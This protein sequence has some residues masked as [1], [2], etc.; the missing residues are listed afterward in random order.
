MK[1][2]SFQTVKI[3]YSNQENY[4]EMKL[5]IFQTVVDSASKYFGGC[6]YACAVC[7]GA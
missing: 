2:I 5:L 4:L 1:L 7:F 6:G 3:E